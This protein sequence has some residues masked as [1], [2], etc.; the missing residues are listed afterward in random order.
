MLIFWQLFI[1]V[2]LFWFNPNPKPSSVTLRVL[3]IAQDAGAPQLGCSKK[4]CGQ[5]TNAKY[6]HSVVSLGISDAVN[7]QTYLFEAT[8]DIAEQWKMLNTYNQN[9]PVGI[10]LTHAHMGHYAGLLHLGKEAANMQLVNVFVLPR[11]KSFL[12]SNA[13]WN[14]LVQQNNITL[15]EL[16]FNKKYQLSNSIS[17]TPVQ[18]PHRDELSE[19]AAFLI[20]G[21]SKT[22]LFVPDIDKWSKWQLRLD[23]LVQKV[24]YA[25]LDGTFYHEHEL[26]GRKISEVPHPTVTETMDLLKELSISDKQKVFFIHLNHTNDL[27]NQKSIAYKLVKANGFNIAGLNM[28]FTL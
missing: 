9:K 27:L 23:S 12:L 19:T 3:G 22:A 16:H 7:K 1:A 21:P 2:T 26:P 11:M 4:C 5:K 10:F 8:A 17:V 28:V 6:K 14:L 20:S 18:V 24:D 13:P 15:N 25:F